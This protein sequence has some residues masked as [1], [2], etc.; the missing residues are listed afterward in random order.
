MRDHT[1]V[2]ALEVEN[3]TFLAWTLKFYMSPNI[4]HIDYKYMIDDYYYLLYHENE[5]KEHYIG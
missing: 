1:C 5:N 4:T 3:R 2:M